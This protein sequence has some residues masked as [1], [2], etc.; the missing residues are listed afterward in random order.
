[1]DYALKVKSVSRDLE[2]AALRGEPSYVWRE[3]QQ[4][5]FQMILDASSELIKG[6]V[7]EN[8]CGVG[9]YVERMLPHAGLVVGLEYDLERA[10]QARSRAPHILGAA[11]E[12]LPFRNGSFD[13]I[14]SHEVLEHV[15]DDRRAIV[16]MV[17]VVRP[18][19]RIIIFV[20]NRGYPFETHG[21][22]LRGKYRF[23]NIPL[24]NYLPT[25][26]R[27]YF[28]PHVRVYSRGVLEKLFSGLPVT[29]VR[30]AVIFGG[31]DN[32]IT[33]FP[34][35]GKALRNLLHWMEGTPLSWFGLSHFWVV[36]KRHELGEEYQSR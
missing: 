1:M 21:V 6:H 11:S 13:V 33:R 25:V 17:R 10:E 29:I 5:R 2:K 36:E 24:I 19:G 3:G 23:G 4:R 30:K 7:L 15:N 32:I 20:P 26:M 35:F 14:L 31:Y 27:N 9:M 8:G 34:H 12:N 28:A 18:G 22:Y 16:E